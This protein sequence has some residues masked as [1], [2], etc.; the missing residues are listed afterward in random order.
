MSDKKSGKKSK[1]KITPYKMA[2]YA[3]MTILV[4]QAMEDGS[5]PSKNGSIAPPD[6]IKW[7]DSIGAPIP[8][9]MRTAVKKY[10]GDGAAKDE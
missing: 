6:F 9:K 3:M 10:H 5:L 8:D 7:A 2:Q 1:S 4:K